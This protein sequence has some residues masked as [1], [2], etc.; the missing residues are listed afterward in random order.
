MDINKVIIDEKHLHLSIRKKSSQIFIINMDFFV[1]RAA[2]PNLATIGGH[3][4]E[5]LLQGR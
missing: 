5:I 4:R 3:Y 2:K 1:T